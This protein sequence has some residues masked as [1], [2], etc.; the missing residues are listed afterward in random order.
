VNL[1]LS[2]PW[3]STCIFS[4]QAGKIFLSSLKTLRNPVD[5]T[6]CIQQKKYFL[7]ILLISGNK[8]LF[9]KFTLISILISL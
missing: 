2:L 6:R 5:V 8:R 1:H 3:G 4:R 7:Q 9:D